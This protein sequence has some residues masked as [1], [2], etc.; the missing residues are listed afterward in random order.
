MHVSPQFRPVLCSSKVKLLLKVSL[1][2]E[3]S[4]TSDNKFLVT[5]ASGGSPL[6][7]IDDKQQP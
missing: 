6:L 7:V 5:L 3:G 4:G 1:L 2:C